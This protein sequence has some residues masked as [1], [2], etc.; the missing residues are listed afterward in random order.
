MDTA[1]NV[2]SDSEA[3]GR[4]P[5]VLLPAPPGT[6]KQPAIKPV[7]QK[8]T[9]ACKA[10]RTRKIRC[11]GGIP[12]CDRCAASNTTCQYIETEAR[13]AR[14]RYK[15]LRDRRSAH[16]ELLELLTTLSDTDSFEVIRRLKAGDD[17]QRLLNQAK[18]GDLLMQISLVPETRRRYDLPYVASMPESILNQDNHYLNSVVFQTSFNTPEASRKALTHGAQQSEYHSMYL[19]PYH[20]AE[21]VDPLLDVSVSG[22]TSVISDNEL[23]RHLLGAY[24]VHQ[25]P[26]FFP[27]HKDIFLRDM[28]GRRARFCSPLLVNAVLAAGAQCC[29]SISK[30]NRFWHPQNLA[31]RFTAEANRLWDLACLGESK[32]T[33]IQAATIL[34]RVMNLNGLDRIGYAYLERSLAMAHDLQIFGSQADEATKMQKVRLVTAWSLFNWQVVS[35]YY[36]FRP[37][38]L[39]RPPEIPLPDPMAHSPWYGE[40]WL[41]YPADAAPTVIS[42]G[43]DFK[44]RSALRVIM[45][46]I[47]RHL[48]TKSGRHRDLSLDRFLGFRSRLENW[49]SDLPEALTPDKIALPS[50]FELHLEYHST[51]SQLFQLQVDNNTRQRTSL[52]SLLTKTPE[53]LVASAN[54]SLETLLRLYYIRHSY[55]SHNGMIVY[56]S[57]LVGNMAIEAL[58]RARNGTSQVAVDEKVL[59]QTLILCAR[60]LESQGQ[61]YHLAN[62]AFRAFQDRVDPTDL[63]VLQ[64]YCKP[65]DLDAEQDS[66][67]QHSYSHWPLPII[68]LNEDPKSATLDTLLEEYRHLELEDESDMSIDGRSTGE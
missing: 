56:F 18:D 35:S 50:Q 53:D 19:M 3:T 1:H 65:R 4:N 36:F 45:N 46:E 55:D 29:H 24:F 62:L 5:P 13:E 27:F 42:Y 58:S 43:C 48:Y 15:E 31:Y 23:L 12:T 63:Q 26:R 34:N 7:R 9:A 11:N 22:W 21:M 17:V 52:A 49:F 44:E 16:E 8:R 66:I 57:I 61:S 20:A 25:H 59:R 38:F 68:K 32:L 10:C 14:R 41:L 47:A 64:S 60:G 39:N 51:V 54:L 33:T 28:G 40:L 6:R 37:P 67:A 30:R 2:R